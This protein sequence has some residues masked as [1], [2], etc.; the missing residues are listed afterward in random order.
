MQD[1]RTH[2]PINQ[3]A[4]QPAKTNTVAF[5]LRYKN[6]AYRIL[7]LKAFINHSF[8]YMYIVYVFIY[9]QCNEPTIHHQIN[10]NKHILGTRKNLYE[11]S[12]PKICIHINISTMNRIS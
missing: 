2:Q 5:Q 8:V 10:L 7:T 1:K 11:K 12:T 4:K 3:T 9:I 6:I